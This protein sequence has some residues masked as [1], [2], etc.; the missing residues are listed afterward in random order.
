MTDIEILIG[1]FTNDL[2]QLLKAEVNQKLVARVVAEFG[3]HA[4][5]PGG[6]T[7]GRVALMNGKTRRKGPVQLCP[8]P[9][10]SSRAAPVFGMVCSKHKDLPK[11]QIKKYREARRKRAE[12]AK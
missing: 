11:A 3:G 1:K 4:T 6:A 12:A 10:C 7:R 2:Y 5:P 8:V 9:R